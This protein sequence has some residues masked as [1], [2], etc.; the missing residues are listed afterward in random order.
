MFLHVCLQGATLADIR[1]FAL[2][3]GAELVNVTTEGT[4]GNHVMHVDFKWIPLPEQSNTHY[5]CFEAID[6]P[7]PDADLLSSGQHCIELYV[8]GTSTLNPK[9]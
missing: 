1:S 5:V 8:N 3:E 6:N 4:A 9:P 7:P 2:P